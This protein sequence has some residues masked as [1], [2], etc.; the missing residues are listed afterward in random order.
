MQDY[1][2]VDG[3]NMIGAWPMFLELKHHDLS[4]ARDLLIEQLAEYRACSK[5]EV[6]VVFDAYHVK[7]REKREVKYGVE[8]I[9]TK[10]KETADI[11][12]ERLVGELKRIDRKIYVAT[13]DLTEQYTIFSQGALRMSARELLIDITQSNVEIRHSVQEMESRKSRSS[14]RMTEE[15]AKKLENWRRGKI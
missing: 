12:I 1:L 8:I 6:I 14:I 2:V 13:S 11:R 4:M 15:T 7:S 3:Y 10:E 5:R 9:Y